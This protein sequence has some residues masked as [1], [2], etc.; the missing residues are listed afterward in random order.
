MKK[1]ENPLI[2]EITK[3]H[4]ERVFNLSSIRLPEGIKKKCVWCLGNLKGAQRRW[5]ST[6]CVTAAK[7]WGHPQG[8]EG[9]N[10]LLIRQDW[11][12][13]I[14]QY[15]YAPLAQQIANAIDSYLKLGHDAPF[16]DKLSWV[17]V[18]R[19][20]NRTLKAHRPEVD[21]VLPIYKGGQAVGIENCQAICSTCHKAKTRVDLSG[22][23]GKREDH[24]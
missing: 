11:K 9:L 3:S 5:C 13:N 19:I 14:C 4:K 21:H 17:L 8:E 1:C 2:E 24:K 22:K 20:K 10:L 23:R 6:E 12:C 15:D 16:R 7:A 18:K